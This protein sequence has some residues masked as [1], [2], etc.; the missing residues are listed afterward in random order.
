[1][2]WSCVDSFFNVWM[3]L[4]VDL[5]QKYL[6]KRTVYLLWSS[7]MICMFN[8]ESMKVFMAELLVFDQSEKE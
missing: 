2:I 7:S 4:K 3:F 1:M 6:L 8:I 5:L